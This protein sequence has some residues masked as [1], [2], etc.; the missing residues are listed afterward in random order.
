MS[1]R[2]FVA[3]WARAQRLLGQRDYSRQELED[4]LQQKGVAAAVAVAVVERLQQEGWLDEQRYAESFVRLRR[5]RG[6]GPVRIG[7][8]LQ[9]RGVGTADITTAL[10]MVE[11]VEW[12]ASAVAARHK[13]F[14]NTAI[15]STQ[16][17]ARQYRF[18]QYRGF[19]HDQIQAALASGE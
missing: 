11:E 3:G 10:M 12:V 14:G 13:R 5:D 17:R 4:R 7:R 18:L 1:P 9:Q 6:Q 2:E 19:S 16:E 15:E 8:E